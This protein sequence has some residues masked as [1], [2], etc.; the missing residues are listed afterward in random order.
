MV[1]LELLN[2]FLPE[3]KKP[4]MIYVKRVSFKGYHINTVNFHAAMESHCDLSSLYPSC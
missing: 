2:L 3:G 1:V 4:I